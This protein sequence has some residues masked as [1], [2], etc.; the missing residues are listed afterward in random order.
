VVDTRETLRG[1]LSCLHNPYLVLRFAP[2]TGPSADAP[3]APRL[4]VD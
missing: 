2:P 3:H 4:P 1:L